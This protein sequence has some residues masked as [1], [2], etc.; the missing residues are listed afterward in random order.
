ML[1]ISTLILQTCY[2]QSFKCDSLAAIRCFFLR[3]DHALRC[4]DDAYLSGAHEQMRMQ[5]YVTGIG[6]DRRIDKSDE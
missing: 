2:C 6:T 5:A 3:A 4:S 1:G